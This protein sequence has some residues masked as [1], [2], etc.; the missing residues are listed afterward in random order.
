[1]QFIEQAGK[2][3]SSGHSRVRRYGP[4]AQRCVRDVERSARRTAVSFGRWA[5]QRGLSGQDV[6]DA[7]GREVRTLSSW[8]QQ[9]AAT[10]LA[11]RPRG[12]ARLLWRRPGTVWA[13]D[14]SYP[15]API[16]GLY[17]RIFALRD[18]ASGYQ[19]AWDGV[20]DESADH[21]VGIL[22]VLF[23]LHGPPLVIKADNGSPFVSQAV[24]NL[25]R[26]V[27]D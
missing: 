22:V 13:M 6:A 24:R 12:L 10:Q 2:A 18:L 16:D 5:R 9:W 25:L 11:P 3:R 8:Q 7:L 19:L 27:C 17:T 26:Q 4:A 1:M 23:V 20:P 15:P 21:V 14:H